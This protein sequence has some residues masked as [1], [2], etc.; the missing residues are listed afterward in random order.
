MFPFIFE[1][2]NDASH[3]VFMIPFYLVLAILFVILNICGIGATLDWLCKKGDDH[4]HGE[5]H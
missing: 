4:G 3:F 5:H 2:V 1:W